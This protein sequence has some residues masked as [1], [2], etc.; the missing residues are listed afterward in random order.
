MFDLFKI[1][2]F[3]KRKNINKLIVKNF[4]IQNDDVILLYS[5]YQVIR[6]DNIILI[7]LNIKIK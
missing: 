7:S 4:F 6:F 5:S 2:I 1:S 3:H